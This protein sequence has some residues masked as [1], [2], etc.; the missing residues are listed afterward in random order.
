M[1]HN[2]YDIEVKVR[3]PALKK[4]V[5]IKRIIVKTLF[6]AFLMSMRY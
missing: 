2:D 5:K 6:L 1:L 3:I 4:W